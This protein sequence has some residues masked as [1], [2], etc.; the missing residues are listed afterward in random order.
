MYTCGTINDAVY[1]YDL[2][3]AWDISTITF[4]QSFVTFTQTGNPKEVAFSPDGTRL[5]VAGQNSKIYGYTLSVGWD[6]ST[7][8]FT[9]ETPD[10]STQEAVAESIAFSP[11]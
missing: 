3:V 10:L 7:A 2:S 9:N 8:S 4:N 5:L 6:I 1:E 11:D